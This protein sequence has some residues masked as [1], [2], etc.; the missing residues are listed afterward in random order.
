MRVIIPEKDQSDFNDVL[1]EEGYS[2]LSRQFN[3]TLTP[4]QFDDIST[5]TLISRSEK[6]DKIDLKNELKSMKEVHQNRLIFDKRLDNLPKNN[7]PAHVKTDQQNYKNMAKEIRKDEVRIAKI[8]KESEKKFNEQIKSDQIENIAP[9]IDK[10]IK[11]A[12]KE[13]G[14]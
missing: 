7:Q 5:K 4:K 6:M 2:E 9:S 13:M 14:L 10:K 12:E 11:G 1:K 3:Q 8:N